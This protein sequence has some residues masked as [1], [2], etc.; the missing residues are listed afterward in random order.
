MERHF[1][2]QL[3]GFLVVNGRVYDHVVSLAPVHGRRYLVLVA[4]LQ[5]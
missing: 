5:R 2:E 4:E 1:G 3:L